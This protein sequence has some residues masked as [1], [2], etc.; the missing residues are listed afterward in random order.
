MDRRRPSAAWIGRLVGNS[1]GELGVPVEYA[2]Q[3]MWP[4]AASSNPGPW[5]PDQRPGDNKWICGIFDRDP[6]AGAA[7]W[8]YL[9]TPTTT[10]ASTS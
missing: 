7:R 5:N 8:F 4:V 2:R 9:T 10:T 3:A 1:G 6:D